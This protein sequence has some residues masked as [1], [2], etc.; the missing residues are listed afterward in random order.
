MERKT[1]SVSTRG[2]AKVLGIVLLMVCS[3]LVTLALVEGTLRLVPNLLPD[4]TRL[5]LH[6]REDEGPWYQ[7]HPYIGHLH[8]ADGHA[9]AHT[10]RPGG[11]G[12]ASTRRSSATGGSVRGCARYGFAGHRLLPGRPPPASGRGFGCGPALSAAGSIVPPPG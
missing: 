1:A 7:P 9:S 5:R 10:A 11:E 2:A 12:S 4:G 8:Q 3:L 6:W